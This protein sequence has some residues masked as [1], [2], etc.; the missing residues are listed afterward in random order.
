M[1]FFRK[2]SNRILHPRIGWI[3]CLHR[4]VPER[5]PFKS[6]RDLEITPDYL[7]DLIK[8]KRRKGFHFVDLD[9]FVDVAS[10]I[11]WR[12]KLV[13]ITFDDGFADVFQYA[14]PILKK[15]S[16]PF[17]IYVSTGMPDGST[18][19]WWLQLEQLANGDKQ[20][21]ERTIGQIY[22]QGTDIA[23]T[24]HALTG[25]EIDHSFCRQLSLTWEQLRI[26]VSEGLC[27]IGSHGVSHSAMSL[28]S[29][30]A[31]MQELLGSRRR[32]KEMLDV[33]VRHFSYPHSMFNKATQ[34]LVWESGFRTAVVGYGGQTRFMKGNRFFNREFIVQP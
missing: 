30:E 26:M 19:L 24:M 2:I 25:S 14:Y 29:K 23:A 7:E 28:L 8:E 11:P 12:R 31:A 15:Y 18:D 17:T 21:F 10:R 34:Q 20:W 13:H 16:I 1:T 32:L 22:R 6:N 33:E 4:V 9:T 5:S 27:S 3:W